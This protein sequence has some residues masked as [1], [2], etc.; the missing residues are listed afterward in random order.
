M[1]RTFIRTAEVAAS[2]GVHPN[3]V[4]RYEEWGYLPPIP[5]S[6]S[7]YRMFTPQHVAQMK[8]AH[9]ALQWP[10]PGGKETVIETVTSAAQGDLGRALEA[11][12]RYLANVRAERAHAEAAVEFLDR[13]AQGQ[14]TDATSQPLRIGAI[15][16]RLGVTTDMLRNWERNGLLTV[17]RDPSSGY[18]Q[19]GP[20]EIGRVRVIRM[21]RQAGYSTM[22][23][24][25]MLLAFDQGITENLRAVLDTPRADEEDMLY[26]ADRWLSTLSTEE[27]RAL[28]MIVQLAAM[29]A[30]SAHQHRN[31]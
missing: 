15:A 12:Y 29:F 7:G 1:P 16:A 22:A 25:R 28:D 11:A 2:V 21:L 18:R 14:T 6:P 19:Y 26:V 8:L 10:Y 23:I 13:W 27:Q 17:P 4:R 3:T 30:E 5:R 24:L 20:S 9:T 31:S